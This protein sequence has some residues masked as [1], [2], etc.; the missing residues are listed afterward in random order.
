MVGWGPDTALLSFFLIVHF[1]STFRLPAMV[2]VRVECTCVP[3]S[4]CA[5]VGDYIWTSVNV[6]TCECMCTCKCVGVGEWVECV[7]LQ[8]CVQTHATACVNVRARCVH[9]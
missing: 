2:C 7:C 6:R 3:A 9:V 8:V 5:S 4:V 1:G